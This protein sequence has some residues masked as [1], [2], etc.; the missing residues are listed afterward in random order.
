YFCFEPFRK[1]VRTFCAHAMQAAGIFVSALSKFSA[2]VQICQ[3]QLNR[4][5]FPFGMNI[6]GNAAAIVSHRDRSIDM[7][8][9][10]DL[11]TKSREM[12][13]DG[14][15]DDFVD[16]VMQPTLMILWLPEP[17]TFADFWR[18]DRA[19][20]NSENRVLLCAS[21]RSRKHGGF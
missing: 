8:G 20:S 7:N 21:K 9:Q 16:Q 12:F 2:G 11:R 17:A 10:F 4:R 18:L 3:H 1:R 13:V 6:D 19:V 5:H 15:I 14:V